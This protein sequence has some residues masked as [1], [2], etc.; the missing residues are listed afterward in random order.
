MA[1]EVGSPWLLLGVWVVCGL[2]SLTGALC[3]AEMGA[4]F[5][6]AGGQ[7]VFLRQAFG[8]RAAFLY[9]WTFFWVIQTGII[10]AVATA[11]AGFLAFL[12]PLTPLQVKLVAMALIAV[13]SAVNYVGVK[14]GAAV[15]DLFTGLKVLALV[16][17]V[18]LGFTIAQARTS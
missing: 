4:M 9:G 8:D 13:L 14:Y 16:A 7:Y 15:S 11:F 12:W 1:R 17:L 18:A 3:F 2:L 5:P 10:A 6:R